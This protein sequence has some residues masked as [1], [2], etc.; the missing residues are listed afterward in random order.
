MSQ[1]PNTEG[2]R[3]FASFIL[4]DRGQQL[5]FHPDIRKLPIKPSVYRNK[6]EGYF[7]PFENNPTFIYNGR[8]GLTRQMQQMEFYHLALAVPQSRHQQDPSVQRGKFLFIQSQ[9]AACHI[10]QVTTGDFP[11]LSVLSGKTIMPYS[12]F[13]LHDMGPALADGRPD[14]LASGSEWRTPPLWGIGLANTVDE[15]AGFLHDG[16]ALTLLEAIL[17]HGGEAEYVK[18]QVKAMPAQDRQS[19]IDFLY[20]L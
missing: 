16:R 20:S 18:Q 7:N 4:S 1:A 11:Q 10:P 5:L 13:L 2:A 12:D 17:W 15:Q 19:L 8:K 14:F 6:P 9:C 3:A